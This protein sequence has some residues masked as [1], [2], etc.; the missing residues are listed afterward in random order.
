ML[1]VLDGTNGSLLDSLQPT[2]GS[3]QDENPAS[4]QCPFTDSST[5]TTVSPSTTVLTLF[6]MARKKKE[7]ED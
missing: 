7:E 6:L 2:Y 1:D 3:Q 5:V 4:N